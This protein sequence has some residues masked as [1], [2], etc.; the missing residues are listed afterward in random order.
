MKLDL[1]QNF[2]DKW[3]PNNAQNYILTEMANVLDSNRKF[4]VICAP[5]GSGKSMIAKTLCNCSSYPTKEFQRD[6][7][8]GAMYDPRKIKL[9]THYQRSGCAVLTCTKSLQDQ[10]VAEFTDGKALKGM[11]NYPCAVNEDHTY[12][13]GICKFVSGQKKICLKEGQ[14]AY[15]NQRAL[16]DC[17]RSQFFNYSILFQRSEKV[18]FKD[19]I[20]CDEASE[21][22]TLLVNEYTVAILVE[23]FVNL[24]G[25]NVPP[26]PLKN[27]SKGEYLE[28]IV[29]CQSLCE[30]E[31]AALEHE[32]AENTNKKS[33]K[34]IP[35]TE[36][37]R[38]RKLSE[39]SLKLKIL[40]ETW[41]KTEYLIENEGGML[42]FKPYNVDYLADRYLFSYGTNVILMSATIIDHE[43]FT[44]TLGINPNDYHYIEAP[45]MFDPA[46]APIK[47]VGDFG[48]TYAN[49][50]E[51]L[52][53]VSQIAQKLCE[54]HSGEKGIIHSHSMEILEYVRRAMGGDKRFL[55]REDDRT[56]EDLIKQHKLT[57]KDTV[58]V[59]PSMTHGVDLKGDLGK[60]QLI[61]KAPFS[62]M[63]D[64]R[65]KRKMKEDPQWYTNMMLSTLVQ[66]CGRCNR[67]AADESVTYILDAT[68]WNTIMRNLKRLPEYFRKRL[69]Q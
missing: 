45:S 20:V 34:K 25:D 61:M 10:Y 11:V 63:G 6:C 44:K 65:I 38:H 67:T 7:M 24:L 51:T 19:Y 5:T 3:T 21:L 2:P 66:A 28:W 58:L 16:T 18:K 9:D 54:A 12:Q 69:T 57:T 64:N 29:Q 41:W 39:Y 32:W 59:S 26:T 35:Y 60:F 37:N 31:V 4:I 27:S 68:A 8:S 62:P 17:N 56:N 53:I 1:I 43:N 49:K 48:I 14:C 22:E 52:P 47:K 36:L 13:D 30:G 42:I 55:Y 33:K 50:R 46:K 23:N 15:M 40:A